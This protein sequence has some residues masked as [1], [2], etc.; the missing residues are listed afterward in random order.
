MVRLPSVLAVLAVCF[1]LCCL[2]SNVQLSVS[3]GEVTPVWEVVWGN[4]GSEEGFYS[5]LDGSGTTI[6]HRISSVAILTMTNLIVGGSLVPVVC[7][8]SLPLGTG[9]VFVGGS[10][11][12][13]IGTA[14]TTFTAANVGCTDTYIL[15]YTPK[16]VVQW[17]RV[18]QGS[19]CEYV[20]NERDSSR[21]NAAETNWF[22]EFTPPLLL[23]VIAPLRFIPFPPIQTATCTSAVAPLVTWAPLCRHI[24]QGHTT[25]AHEGEERH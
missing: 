3:A 11:D 17:M 18:L 20:S 6:G 22:D 8:L 25:P 15:K 14:A 10:T 9:S 12:G 16:G 7:F 13:T 23:C 2:T 1:C 5:A 19:G 24:P 21:G 4:S